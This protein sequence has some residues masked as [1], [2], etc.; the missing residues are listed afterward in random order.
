[1]VVIEVYTSVCLSAYL[2]V[3]LCV[4]GTTIKN[5]KRACMEGKALKHC[6]ARLAHSL[7]GKLV[8]TRCNAQ[9]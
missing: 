1:M 6:K 4:Y 2:C 5:T 9:D 3:C 8:A 7:T